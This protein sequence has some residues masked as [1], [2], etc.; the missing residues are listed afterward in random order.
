MKLTT[1]KNRLTAK[2]AFGRLARFRK[3]EDGGMI[4]FSLI[5]FVLILT[6]G[7]IAVDLM[8]FEAVRTKLQGTL[9]RATLAAADLDQTIPPADIVVDYFT[10]AGM[11]EFLDGDPIIDE[12][13]SYRIVT[14]NAKAE[15]PLFFF[16]LPRIFLSPLTDGLT[17]L[18]VSGSSTAEERLSN[19]EVSLVLD[20]SGS[21]AWENRIIHMRQAAREFVTDL[22]AN[23]ANTS[24]GLITISLI[25]YNSAVNPGD[26][27]G[28]ELTFTPTHNYSNCVL[29]DTADFHDTAIDLDRTYDKMGHFA[30]N[31]P[32][33]PIESPECNIGSE[34]AIVLHS[35]HEGHLHGQ[36]DALN[37]QGRTAIDVGMKWGA[38]LLDESTQDLTTAL[39]G[40]EPMNGDVLAAATGRP[41]AFSESDILKVIILMTD[42][43]NVDSFDL[44]NHY[45]FGDHGD[46]NSFDF[47]YGQS[48]FWFDRNNASEDLYDVSESRIWYQYR[49]L[50]TPDRGDD[51][52]FNL[53]DLGSESL[54]NYPG[55]FNDQSDYIDALTFGP[56]PGVGA[57]RNYLHYVRHA[58]WQDIFAEWTQGQVRDNLMKPAKDH[59]VISGTQDYAPN[60]DNI[61]VTSQQA[62]ANL[63][64]ICEAARNKGI[65]IYTVA[66]AAA[67]SGQAALRNCA[68]S[69]SH[70]FDV[71]GT[72]IVD[73]FKAIASDIG[74]LK[75]TQ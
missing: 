62:D 64:E 27:I 22:L 63:A 61:I 37:P 9:D 4:I 12:R 56:N 51:L 66:F 69:P 6:F 3:D 20:T 26:R 47:K 29:F 34:N 7:G 44:D 38:S 67:P 50:N 65:V 73:A 52:F 55:G 58:S 5:L 18:T 28:N 72:G 36:I 40:T 45:F 30:R 32:D 54:R 15:M 41:N 10:K 57:G 17:S 49:G 14:A 1:S 71:N 19:V 46:Q 53:D 24:Q 48:P 16:D 21:M 33:G 74:A 39:T 25:P 23:N 70:Y 2:T 60:I 13:I 59:G 42:G 31:G 75:L 11:I 43:R 8:R 68:S 35:S